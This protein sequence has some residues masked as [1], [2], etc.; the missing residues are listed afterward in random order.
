MRRLTLIALT[1]FASAPL[2]QA[3]AG[4]GNTKPVDIDKLLPYQKAFTNLPLQKRTEFIKHQREAAR[5]FSE[6]RVI[7]SLDALV[8]A[9]RVFDQSPELHNLR[10]SCYVELR[11]FE[12]SLASF[13][14]ALEISGGNPS[15]LFNV[16]EVYFVT[17]KWQQAHDNF[18]ALLKNL[19]KENVGL[20][21]ITEFKLM[22]CKLKL[23][24][25]QEAMALAEKYDFLD[26]SPYHYFAKATLAYEKDD[27]E[28]AEQWIARAGRIFRNPAILAPW[29][30]TMVEYG[31][32]K[33]FYGG[34]E[35]APTQ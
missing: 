32:I 35:Q 28:E 27:L 31:Y 1:I 2:L 4:L 19:P 18:E 10:G 25:E 15:I 24:K 20:G 23:D 13:R 33:S 26:D 6:K 12:K 30:D 17:Q 11:A 8:L 22:L 21:R 9:E 3:Q 29:H 16:G 34:P 7:E 14:K 5:L